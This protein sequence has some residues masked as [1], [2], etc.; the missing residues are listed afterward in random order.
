M[1]GSNAGCYFI[2]S[3]DSQAGEWLVVGVLV[4]GYSWVAGRWTTKEAA[5]ASAAEWMALAAAS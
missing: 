2:V 5:E 1:T 3:E 4:A